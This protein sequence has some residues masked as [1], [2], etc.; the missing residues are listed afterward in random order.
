MPHAQEQ[1]GEV[2]VGGEM[3]LESE[4]GLECVCVLL[5]V[6]FDPL[7]YKMACLAWL[8]LK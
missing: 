6:F 5:T 7:A 3:K 8:R 1:A 2:E 4:Y